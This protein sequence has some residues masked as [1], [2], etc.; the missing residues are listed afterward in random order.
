MAGP[1]DDIGTEAAAISWPDRRRLPELDVDPVPLA[2]EASALPP[3]A[4][5]PHFNR[6]IYTGDW[7]GVA[8]RALDGDPGRLYPAMGLPG[9]GQVWA[10]TPW[11][12]ACP[13]TAAVLASLPFPVTSARFLCLGPGAEIRPH[14]DPG[15]GAAHGEARLHLALVSGPEVTFSV[16]G[17]P[18]ELRPGECWYL[19]LD[20]EHTA[21]NAGTAP[22]LH[23]VVD[24]VLDGHLAGLL[25]A[26]PSSGP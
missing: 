23:L 24:A 20:R 3:H 10:P 8:L 22:R 19:D 13:A 1:G 5:I 26:V 25:T 21:A 6:A 18:V 17:D 16:A 2:A 7:S 14:R 11:L 9:V 12:A 4:W 15:L